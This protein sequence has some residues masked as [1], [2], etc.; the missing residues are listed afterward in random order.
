MEKSRKNSN[1]FTDLRKRAAK[2]VNGNVLNLPDN[3]VDLPLSV[4]NIRKLIHELRVYH[5]ELEMQNEELQHAQLEQEKS[6]ARFFDLYN[7]APFGYVTLGEDY[8][9]QEINL[10]GASLLGLE[11]SDLINQPLTRFIVSEDQDIFY[12]SHRKVEKKETCELRMLQKDGSWFWAQL[13]M[14]IV[15]DSELKTNE[16]R[17]VIMDITERKKAEELLH[18][19]HFELEKRVKERTIELEEAS[20]K[21]L[22]S[23]EQFQQIIEILPV[24]IICHNA[25]GVIFSNSEAMKLVNSVS[26]QVFKNQSFI[27]F[28]HP[29]DKKSY[30]DQFNQ[31]LSEEVPLKSFPARIVQVPGTI[32]DVELFLAPFTYQGEPAVH[33]T[34]YN[35]TRRKRN[36]VELFKAEKLQS[37]SILAGGIAH[38]FNNYLTVLLGNISMA[39]SN[40]NDPEKLYKYLE[41]TKEATLQTKKLASQLLVFAK[42]G[43]PVKEWVAIDQ[44]IIE[45]ANF[46]LSGSNVSCHFSI[47]EGLFMVEIDKGQITQVL[48][49]IIINSVQALSEGGSIHVKAENM[50]LDSNKDNNVHLATG[51]YVNIS[52]TDSGPGIPE[53]SLRKIFDPFFTTKEN[54]N[55]LGL[56]GAYTIIKNHEGFI[57][58]ESE[59]GRG[60]T[61]SFKIPASSRYNKFIFKNDNIIYGVGKILVMDDEEA[62]R[63][64]VGHMLTFMGYEPHFA[65]DGND[66]VDSYIRAKQS[67]QPFDLVILD[68]TI[69]GG[70]GGE[71]T[72]KELLSQDPEVKAIVSSGYSKDPIISNFRAYGFK[73]VAKKPFSIEELSKIINDTRQS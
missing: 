61:L 12:L 68:M 37:I 44:L 21:A 1:Q 46:V 48:Y 57:N 52:V 41:Y 64:V 45:S 16:Y 22:K 27:A 8:R 10:K 49:N 54:G 65:K 36:E 5:I 28:L 73:G 47:P 7:S 6:R 71:S 56:A 70:K 23:E 3:L 72:I 29:E 69:K 17:A 15:Y 9:I 50:K 40:K 63:E 53:Q 2:N 51:E 33:I 60:T 34:A 25:T 11:K 19:N 67:D 66:A 62:I 13:E 58:A 14:T 4:D 24:A 59:V 42:G 43:K 32:I 31:V 30:T 35:V 18:N 38:D 39:M 20:Y 55:G 26:K